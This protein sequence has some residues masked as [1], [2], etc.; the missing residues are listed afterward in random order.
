VALA[1][2]QDGASR[3]EAHFLK[4]NEMNRLF[5]V[6]AATAAALALSL[7]AHARV[8][9]KTID[10]EHDGQ[11]LQGYLVWDDAKPGAK[12]GVLVIH[13]WW[14]L[15][16][17][18]KSRAR[19]LA[20]MGYVAF[21]ADMFGAGKVTR[22]AKQ[23]QAWYTEATSKPGL[24]AARSKA[25]LDILRKQSGVDTK[26]LA[27]IGFCFGGTTVLQLAYSGEPLNGVV[28][29][30]GGLV[31]PDDNQAKAI[32]TPILILHGAEDTFIK[33]EAISGIQKALDTAKVDWYMVTY[34]HAVHAFTNPQADS[35]KI[36]GIGYNEKA[37]KRSWEEMGRFFQTT[38]K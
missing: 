36:P 38:L 14:G 18:T 24:L 33:P 20:E 16:D 19:Q 28:T 29:F 5:A 2:T 12:P 23:A 1:R 15:N 25:G 30:H 3:G 17:Y 4:E 10:Y 27:A 26:H 9:A 22:D 21:A 13:E 11:K 6:A 8:V 35:F 37:A 31:V 32:K 34:A 7:A